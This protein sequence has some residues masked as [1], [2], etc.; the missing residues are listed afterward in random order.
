MIQVYV[1]IYVCICIS[2]R[3]LTH[4]EFGAC[5]E[6]HMANSG[7]Y[8]YADRQGNPVT[9]IDAEG[10]CKAFPCNE[11]WDVL[12]LARLGDTKFTQ[13]LDLRAFYVCP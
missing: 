9:S 7:L 13:G 3:G 6:K 11:Q 4:S 5:R 2:G 8:S 1:Y 10:L 12:N